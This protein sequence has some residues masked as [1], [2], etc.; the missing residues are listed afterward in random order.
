[1]MTPKRTRRALDAQV[2]RVTVI[3]LATTA[4][5]YMLWR[6]VDVL[7]LI[8]ACALVALILLTL[9][10][11]I[12]RRL[13]LPFGVALTLTVVLLIAVVGGAA[14]FFGAAMSQ[15]FAD[16]IQRLPAAWAELQLRLQRTTLGQSIIERLQELAP[17]GRTIVDTLTTVVAALGGVLSGL[18]IV[19]VGGLYLAA[20]P[21]LYGGGLMKLIPASS[22]TRSAETF[23]AITASL[24]G[25][26]KGQALGMVFV[27]IGTGIGLSLIGL[28][29]APAIGMVAGLAEFVPYLGAI[30]AGIPAVILGFSQSTETGLWTIGVLILVQQVQG[31]LVMPLLQNR[32]VDLPP[33]ITIFG[34]IVAGVLLGPV[35]VLLATPLTVVILV[36]VRRLYLGEGVDEVLASSDA[37]HVTP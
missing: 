7:L 25:W 32:M 20:Q 6:L 33:A 4:S 2:F 15:Q 16:L 35:G 9:T 29:A 21:M 24:R 28:P 8:F 3:V 5:A 30:V 31:N 18:A 36:L 23:E 27:G 1:M 12:R 34:I 26:L 14:W 11:V 19:L 10:R 17:S 22:R 13:P 37:P